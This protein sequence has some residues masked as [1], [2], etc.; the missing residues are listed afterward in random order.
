MPAWKKVN[1][2][3][4]GSRESVIDKLMITCECGCI[5]S[6][7]II[8]VETWGKNTDPPKTYSLILEG[9]C[10]A[11]WRRRFRNG[12]AY[13]FGRRNLHQW[14]EILISEDDVYEMTDF[15]DSHTGI[16]ED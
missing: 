8:E 11:S 4:T 7:F 9:I 5:D 1:T 14:V 12:M 15:L 6:R 3:K 10:T 16:T 13:I 2:I